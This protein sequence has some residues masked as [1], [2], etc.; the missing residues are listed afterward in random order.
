MKKVFRIHSGIPIDDGDNSPYSMQLKYALLIGL[1]PEIS[2]FVIKHLVGWKNVG[3]QRTIDYAVH[4]EET[5]EA[6]KRKRKVTD[7]FL[8]STLSLQGP[9]SRFRLHLHENG[10]TDEIAFRG[11]KNQKNHK[12]RG[13]GAGGESRVTDVCYNCG[14]P[15]HYVRDCRAPKKLGKRRGGGRKRRESGGADPRQEEQEGNH[16]A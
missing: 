8:C 4:A 14:K 2:Q 11:N 1:R 13:G 12:G 6:K 16:S 7:T 10:D 9:E 5:I 15:G 3:L